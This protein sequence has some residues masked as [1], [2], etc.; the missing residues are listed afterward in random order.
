MEIRR[1][2]LEGQIQAQEDATM[3][4]I[5][6]KDTTRASLASNANTLEQLVSTAPQ[7]ALLAMVADLT[8]RLDQLQSHTATT[9]AGQLQV[10]EFTVDDSTLRQLKSDISSLGKLTLYVSAVTGS[11]P[12]QV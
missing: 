6:S 9:T 4:A 2:E 12:I 8:S 5:K 10:P 3:P 11:E 1:Q 7:A